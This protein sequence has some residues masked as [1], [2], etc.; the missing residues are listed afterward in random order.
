MSIIAHSVIN[1][2]MLSM[3]KA[4]QM[5]K[6]ERAVVDR[7]RALGRYSAGEYLGAKLLAELP[8]D[9]VVGAVS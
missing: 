7:E 9:A 2:G 1:V 3:V 6:R 4:L 5:F 8:V